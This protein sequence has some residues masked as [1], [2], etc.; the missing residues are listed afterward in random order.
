M[1]RRI[2]NP[3]KDL[4]WSAFVN[5]LNGLL[6]SQQIVDWVTYKP[7]KILKLRWCKSSRL[8][9]RIAFLVKSCYR[10]QLLKDLMESCFNKSCA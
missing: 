1:L 5:T 3:S 10:K 9:Q 7:P 6:F 2:Y 8:L 4:Q